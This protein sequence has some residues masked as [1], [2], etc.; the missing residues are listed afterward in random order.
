MSQS[1]KEEMM[2]AIAQLNDFS[3]DESSGYFFRDGI[4][5]NGRKFGLSTGE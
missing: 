2:K 3:F 4:A 5:V 1:D